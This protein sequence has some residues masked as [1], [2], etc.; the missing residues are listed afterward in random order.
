MSDPRPHIGR[1]LELWHWLE[2]LDRRVREVVMMWRVI[3]FQLERK[4]QLPVTVLQVIGRFAYGPAI[5]Y[6]L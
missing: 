5:T 4:L 1:P 3:A 2:E 6:R